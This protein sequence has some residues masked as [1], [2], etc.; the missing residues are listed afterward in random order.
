MVDDLAENRELVRLMLEALGHRVEEAASGGEAVST[1]AA[2]AFDLILM[3][4]QMPG[5]DGLTAARL[6]RLGQGRNSATPILA[7]SANVMADQVDQCLCAGM[8][9]HV[10]KPLQVADLVAKVT[11][12]AGRDCDEPPLEDPVGAQPTVNA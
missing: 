10:A 1:A 2:R 3:D 7:L 6:I 5:M 8:N 9:D 4:V 12:W 11:F